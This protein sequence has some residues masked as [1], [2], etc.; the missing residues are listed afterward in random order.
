MAERLK[1]LILTMVLFSSIATA[2]AQT[3]SDKKVQKTA[4][5]NQA[6]DELILDDILIEAVIEKPNVTIL[7]TR[8]SKKLGEIDF[9]SRS[10]AKE[11]KAI[12]EKSF[13]FEEN[14]GNINIANH[15]KTILKRQK[16]KNN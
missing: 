3:G 2:L 5:N 6:S 15:L 9:I 12:P 1:P 10:F 14:F 4:K 11:L 8:K 13:L 7:P 16:A